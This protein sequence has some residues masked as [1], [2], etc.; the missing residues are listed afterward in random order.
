[1]DTFDTVLQ[2]MVFVGVIMGFILLSANYIKEC[3]DE[4]K[5]ANYKPSTTNNSFVQQSKKHTI[6]YN[7]SNNFVTKKHDE[8]EIE[9]N[10]N[11]G[12]SVVKTETVYAD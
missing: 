5:R 10:I 4:H 8:L 12:G 9:F 3:V 1:M 11:L 6:V 7:T 2:I